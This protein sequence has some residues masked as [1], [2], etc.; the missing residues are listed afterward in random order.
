MYKIKY[1]VLAV[2]TWVA[3][4]PKLRQVRQYKAQ[5]QRATRSCAD[6]AGSIP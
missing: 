5:L 4:I 6:V 3:P 1:S 2:S